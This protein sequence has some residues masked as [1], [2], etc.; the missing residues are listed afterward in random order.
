MYSP[1]APRPLP[2]QKAAMTRVHQSVLVFRLGAALSQASQ[3][4]QLGSFLAH[5]A[6]TCKKGPGPWGPPHPEALLQTAA[7]ACQF[8]ACS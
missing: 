6:A 1:T 4:L 2:Q 5:R 8:Q 3:E 7:A